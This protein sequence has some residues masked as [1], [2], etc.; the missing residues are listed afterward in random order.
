MQQVNENILSERIKPKDKK[1]GS[2]SFLHNHFRHIFIKYMSKIS[3]GYLEVIEGSESWSFGDKTDQEK[4]AQMV[5]NDSEFYA[6]LVLGGSVGAAESYMQGLWDCDDLCK[7][8]Q[9]MVLNRDA[10]DSMDSSGLNLIQSFLSKIYH[11]FR[12]NSLEGSRKNIAA[13]YDL[14]NEFFKLM[15]D[16]TMAYSA[17]IYEKKNSTLH[18]ASIEKI[19]RICRKLN[20]SSK[21]HLLEIGTGWGSQAIHAAKHYGCKVTT[22]TISK[23]QHD[24]AKARVKAEGLDHLIE[25]SLKDYRHIEGQYDKLVSVEMIEAVG[26]HYY[27]E[28]FKTCSRLTKPNGMFLLQAIVIDD[29]QYESARDSVDFIKKYIFPGCCIPSQHIIAENIKNETTYQLYHQEDITY[30][31]ARTLHD[32]HIN[33]KDNIDQIRTLGYSD[34][35]CRMWEFYLK[36]CEGK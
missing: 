21:D 27:A 2:I 26:H 33:F 16:P 12:K 29:R 25:V 19:D 30:D 13:H 14:G 24:L 3:K 15:L 35:F 4:R 7:L 31:Y 5:I 9:V 23:E 11:Q 10:L 34:A 8:T 1:A 6:S 22:V 36:Y 20:L 32:W 28:Y 17:G 18:E